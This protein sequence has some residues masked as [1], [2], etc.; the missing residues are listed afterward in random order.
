MKRK[1]NNIDTLEAN[2][3]FSRV[4]IELNKYERFANIFVTERNKITDEICLKVINLLDKIEDNKE[5]L[6][7][8]LLAYKLNDSEKE[9]YYNSK[10]YENNVIKM[11][12]LNSYLSKIYDKPIKKLV[13]EKMINLLVIQ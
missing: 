9:K 1:R 13:A 4:L 11:H 3:I 12:N 5:A 6:K 7:F 2:F 8:E 10:N